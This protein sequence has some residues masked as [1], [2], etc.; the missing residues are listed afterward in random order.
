M[1]AKEFII[2]VA[3]DKLALTPIKGGVTLG[4]AVTN[5]MGNNNPVE[6]GFELLNILAKEKEFNLY[7]FIIPVFVG[8]LSKYPLKFLNLHTDVFDI[9]DNYSNI[10][11]LDL[12]DDFRGI[13]TDG[14]EFSYDSC[15]LN[16]SGHEI[17]AGLIVNRLKKL[18]VQ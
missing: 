13:N 8:D 10:H 18:G 2:E 6:A 3:L 11:C 9:A 17:L 15:H 7:V 14:R 5:K 16:V 1:R 12:L 4:D